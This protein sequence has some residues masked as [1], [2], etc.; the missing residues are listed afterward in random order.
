MSGEPPHSLVGARSPYSTAGPEVLARLGLNVN[1]PLR[2]LAPMFA[3]VL[4]EAAP[5]GYFA[6]LRAAMSRGE[7]VAADS[8]DQLRW[9]AEHLRLSAPDKS[10]MSFSWRAAWNEAVT[11]VGG[12]APRV[13]GAQAK[14][15]LLDELLSRPDYPS[16]LADALTEALSSELRK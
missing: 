2:F 14:R 15:V 3:R 10:E 8:Q 7:V 11:A 5:A 1:M 12:H 13:L 16:R 4:P 9:L 6:A